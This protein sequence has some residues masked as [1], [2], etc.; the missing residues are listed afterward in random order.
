MHRAL[1]ERLIAPW[2][3]SRISTEVVAA[4][5][6]TGVCFGPYRSFKEMVQEDPDCS[7][8]NPLFE[9]VSQP[10]IGD[11]LAPSSPIRFSDASNLGSLTAPVLGQHTEEILAEDLGLSGAHIGRLYDA[12]IVA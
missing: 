12:K 2:F 4:L 8:Q 7:T 1:I 9:R 6:K 5:T 3:A 10:G 11:Y